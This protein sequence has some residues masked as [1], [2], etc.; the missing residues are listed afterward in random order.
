MISRLYVAFFALLLLGCGSHAQEIITYK[1]IE[2]K[3]GDLSLHVFYPP[4]FDKSQPKPA[5]VLFFGGGWKSGSPKQFYPQCQYLA[6]RGM[7]AI[8]AQYRTAKSH[9]ASPK[10][11]VEDGRSAI[12]YVRKHAAQLGVLPDKIAAGG[13]SAGGHVAAATAVITKFD[14]PKDDAS[15]RAKPNAL[16][17]FNPVYD[18]GPTGYGYDRVKDYYKDFSPLHNITA[19]MPPTLT[20]MG[21]RDPLTPPETCHAYKK[22]MEAV[23]VRSDLV[24]FPGQVHGFFNFRKGNTEM[25]VA[26]VSAADA[27]LTSLG[28]LSGEGSVETWLANYENAQSQSKKNPK[29]K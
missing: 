9:D 29:N 10:Q 24:L 3:G 20:M 22:N 23:G 5:I 2:G 21:D 7:V 14:D 1:K 16:V 17:L 6:S 13:G 15:V 19:G 26:T 11:C 28:Y 27:F 8:S 25:F 12:R 18:N 4:G